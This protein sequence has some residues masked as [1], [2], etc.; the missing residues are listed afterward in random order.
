MSELKKNLNVDLPQMLGVLVHPT[1][2][3][4]VL[5]KFW[6]EI[7][8]GNRLVFKTLP[9][10]TGCLKSYRGLPPHGSTPSGYVFT[11]DEQAIALA[12]QFF[13]PQNRLVF[14]VSGH[15]GVVTSFFVVRV[16]P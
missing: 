16:E 10:C 6:M 4:L 3:D 2:R 13:V 5:H 1:T 8:S 9:D 7:Y 11:L 14:K 12:S 15:N